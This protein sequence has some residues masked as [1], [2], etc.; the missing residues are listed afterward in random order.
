MW[1]HRLVCGLLVSA[2][3]LAACK[4]GKSGPV[5][6]W[7]YVRDT[8]FEKRKPGTKPYLRV[9]GTAKNCFLNHPDYCLDDEAFF[10]PLVQQVLDDKHAGVMPDKKSKLR[11]VF[12]DVRRAYDDHQRTADGLK[13]LQERLQARYDKPRVLRLKNEVFADHAFLPFVIKVSARGRFAVASSAVMKGKQWRGE[14]I[15]KRLEELVE[16]HPE[17]DR[18]H[19]YALVP[20]PSSGRLRTLRGEAIH[21]GYRKSTGKLGL[22]SAWGDQKTVRLV[23][24][25]EEGLGALSSGKLGLEGEHVEKCYPSRRAGSKKR[26]MP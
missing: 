5:D 18:F 23:T 7:Q 17:A 25:P 24:L 19:L 16:A 8:L 11:R 6:G 2:L 26:C 12:F 3:A 4:P 14:E 1:A 9:D 13:Q 20:K 21:V 15:G 22:S 10:R